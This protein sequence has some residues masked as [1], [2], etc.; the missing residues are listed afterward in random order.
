MLVTETMWTDYLSNLLWNSFASADIHANFPVVPSV[1]FGD[2]N[3]RGIKF[4]PEV[5]GNDKRQVSEN[6]YYLLKALR[7][8]THFAEPFYRLFRYISVQFTLRLF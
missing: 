5:C 8:D 7:T 3:I 1:F 4:P 2:L 6:F